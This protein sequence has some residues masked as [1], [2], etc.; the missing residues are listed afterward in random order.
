MRLVFPAIALAS[1]ICG[2]VP[3]SGQPRLLVLAHVNVIDV[4]NG[5]G[6]SREQ[7][8]PTITP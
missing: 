7:S 2:Q 8:R 4:T 5:S 3:P 6:A 1:I